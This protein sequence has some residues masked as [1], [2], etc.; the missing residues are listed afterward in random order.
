VA[1]CV[2][3]LASVFQCVFALSQFVF[4]IDGDFRWL[5]TCGCVHLPKSQPQGVGFFTHAIEPKK[6]RRST[7]CVHAADDSAGEDD[8]G[9]WR[10]TAGWKLERY[11]VLALQLHHAQWL[12]LAVERHFYAFPSGPIRPRRRT[13]Q[14][15]TQART[16]IR[17][18]NPESG[19]ER[20]EKAAAS[21][22]S[23]AH[24]HIHGALTRSSDRTPGEIY[25]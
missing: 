19:E 14:A 8:F 25:F 20:T 1:F 10:S 9:D 21:P 13:I 5:F 22:I 18:R 11:E 12:L 15:Q 6:K 17:I 2:N 16:P 24:A 23:T 4:C 7:E 3:P